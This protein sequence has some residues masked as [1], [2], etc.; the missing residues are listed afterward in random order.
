MP[1]NERA[2]LKTRLTSMHVPC[3]SPGPS[4][5]HCNSAHVFRPAHRRG[6]A[7]WRRSTTEGRAAHSVHECIKT[8]QTEARYDSI[9]D[10]FALCMFLCTDDRRSTAA[11]QRSRVHASWAAAANIQSRM[12]TLVEEWCSAAEQ[13]ITVCILRIIHWPH[14]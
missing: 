8:T 3:T 6:A 4:V 12:D 14:V 11:A 5:W 2:E 1:E 10:A 13:H 7:Q 9:M